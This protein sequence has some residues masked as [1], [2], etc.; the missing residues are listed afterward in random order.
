MFAR[1]SSERV[2]TEYQKPLIAAVISFALVFGVLSFAFPEQFRAF[3][4]SLLNRAEAATAIGNFRTENATP[5]YGKTWIASITCR[6]ANGTT[7]RIGGSGNPET[8]VHAVQAAI[9]Q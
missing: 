6:A 8:V 3:S 5:K 1:S 2:L 4:Q 9:N 7:A